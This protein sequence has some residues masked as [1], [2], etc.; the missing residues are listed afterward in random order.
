[1]LLWVALQSMMNHNTTHRTDN[2]DTVQRCSG[3]VQRHLPGLEAL[4]FNVQWGQNN[5]WS[6]FGVMNPFGTSKKWNQTLMSKSFFNVNKSREILGGRPAKQQTRRQPNGVCKPWC[7]AAVHWYWF[8]KIMG[9][10]GHES[11]RLSNHGLQWDH[12]EQEEAHHSPT[13]KN[14]GE[15]RPWIWSTT[16]NN[17][18]LVFVLWSLI[19]AQVNKTTGK[20]VHG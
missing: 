10:D 9:S 5:I 4:C 14:L 12:F 13:V 17:Y 15:S 11:I 2:S 3:S 7:F 1:M 18:G 19:L 6:S 16:A 20:L 8:G